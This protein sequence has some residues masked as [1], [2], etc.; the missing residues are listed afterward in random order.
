M[1]W[2]NTMLHTLPVLAGE[3]AI[4]TVKPFALVRRVANGHMVFA[5]AVA[6]SSEDRGLLSVSADASARTILVGEPIE[7]NL[8]MLYLLAVLILLIAVLLS[9][10]VRTYRS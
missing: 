10:F 3:L 5:T 1:T 7:R 6:F 8:S 2:C 9:L 4:F